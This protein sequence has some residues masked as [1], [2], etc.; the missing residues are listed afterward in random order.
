MIAMV[1]SFS[2]TLVLRY[3]QYKWYLLQWI[4]ALNFVSAWHQNAI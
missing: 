2:R 1:W 3:Y 4:Q